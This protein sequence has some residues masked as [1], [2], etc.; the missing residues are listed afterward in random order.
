MNCPGSVA[1][2]KQLNLEESDEPEYRGLGIAAH[3]AGAHCL[4]NGLDAWEVIGQKFHDVEVDSPMADAIQVYID[5]VLP[6]MKYEG[7]TVYIEHG[8]AYHQGEE[9]VKEIVD[10]HGG[11]G[12]ELLG[13]YFYGTGDHAVAYQ[14]CLEVTDYKHGE[15]IAVDVEENPQL[16]YYAFG[17]LQLHPNVIHVLLRIVQPRIT[18]LE[19]VKEWW[20]E[21]DYI[22]KW[23]QEKLVPA[24][25]HTEIDG[26][27]LDAG[28]WCRFCP[29]K[30]ICPTQVSLFGAACSAN[31]KSIIELTDQSI[32]RSYQYIA[33]V[34]AYI[35]ALEDEAFRRLN[36]GEKIV[37]IKLVP[38]KANRVFK[39]GAV[40]EEQDG[41]VVVLYDS[42]A[43]MLKDKLGEDAMTKPELKSPSQLE[44][45]GAVAKE[46]VKEYA[47]TPQTGL[48]V[49]V[50][51]DRRVAVKVE[52][53]EQAFA[54]ALKNIRTER[55]KI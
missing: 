38:K 31:P 10:P 34:K 12:H 19:P 1:L 53:T 2:I 20:V 7:A 51:T 21:A 15:G 33:S 28:S 30:L 14:N 36:R 16:L 52:T 6:S 11:M 22:R 47:Y 42:V 41:K 29:A 45:L 39:N 37:G 9:G 49:A 50:D 43:A 23:V 13:R 35:K 8:L 46:L 17:F 26:A 5:T 25:L 54:G 4:K 44:E 48:T 40:T 3:E 55:D 24:M 27:E 18:Y 32:G